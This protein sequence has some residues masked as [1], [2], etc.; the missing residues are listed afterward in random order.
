MK[1][2]REESNRIQARF[3]LGTLLPALLMGLI[4]VVTD[5][6]D[7]TV[8]PARPLAQPTAGQKPIAERR[9]ATVTQT[10][11][12]AQQTQPL[13][14]DQPAAERTQFRARPPYYSDSSADQPVYRVHE[15]TREPRRAEI[16]PEPSKG[17]EVFFRGGYVGS[18]SDRRGEVFTDTYTRNNPA[19]KGHYVGAGLDL[20]LT[21]D[22][23]G[24][25]N[26]VSVLGEINVEH[27]RFNSAQ[28]QVAVPSVATGAPVMGKVQVTMLTVSVSPKIKFNEGSAFRP[29]IIPVG[30][31]FQVIS[32]PSNQ[33]QYLDVGVQ[34]GAGAEYQVWKEFKVGVDARFHLTANQTQTVN[35]F[36]TVGPYI[37]I[38]F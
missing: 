3:L 5:A 31:D 2:R 16:L 26:G 11:P 27:K 20:L 35:S 23:W 34:F 25:M 19:D 8:T 33:T 13:E 37:G 32:P 21:R 28:T 15:R 29:W 22:T 10:A 24:M 6:A 18:L 14:S 30:L 1:S 9:T 7:R 17:N 38:G 36:W 4:P 12:E